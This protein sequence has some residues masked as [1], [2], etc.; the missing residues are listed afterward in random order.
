M[1]RFNI[2]LLAFLIGF[3]FMFI[4]GYASAEPATEE[5]LQQV[6]EFIVIACLVFSFCMGALFGHTR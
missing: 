5:T 4:A 2:N 1:S 3:T 6:N